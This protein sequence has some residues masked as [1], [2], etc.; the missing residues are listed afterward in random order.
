MTNARAVVVALGLSLV[1][2]ASL[3]VAL[4][5]LRLGAP[6]RV[7]PLPRLV[8]DLVEPIV[9]LPPAR[10]P[11]PGAAA[12]RPTR[13][14]AERRV[15]PASAPS[16]ATAPPAEVPRARGPA[17]PSLRAPDAPP[18]A[19]TVSPPPAP[20]LAPAPP[21][22]VTAV[23]VGASA[24]SPGPPPV[25]SAPREAEARS[26]GDAPATVA[27]L[28][29]TPGGGVPA[30]ARGAVME[31]APGHGVATA[32]RGDGGGAAGTAT[33]P[34]AGVAAGGEAGRAAGHEVRRAG[35]GGEAADLL[36]ALPARRPG[37]IP[38]EYD[39]YVRALRRR[40]Q[41][42]LVYPWLAVRQ[43]I[44]GTVELEVQLDAAGRLG[45]VAVVGR[46]GAG[47]LREAAVRA[48]RDA[49]PFPF[50]PGLVARALTIRLPIVFELR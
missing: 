29:G 39:G 47:V 37:A 38:P 48:V 35:A 13:P 40:I 10:P 9:A 28:A 30:P 12:P 41:E 24:A 4:R 45:D 21:P 43:G 26:V 3:A 7:D 8:V 50:P 1:L 27:P 34:S 2:H 36:A 16:A 22:A 11:A 33:G 18:P 31:L 44:Q 49:T 46:P 5:G 19:P 14:A 42:R 25:A 15:A 32:E 6:S 20:P 23:P 17:P